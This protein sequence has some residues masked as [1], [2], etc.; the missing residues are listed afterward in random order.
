MEYLTDSNILTTKGRGRDMG[1]G[2]IGGNEVADHMKALDEVQHEAPDNCKMSVY[3]MVEAIKKALRL[4][5]SA[6]MVSKQNR[7]LLSI[8]LLLQVKADVWTIIQWAV[9]KV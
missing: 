9:G 1:N 3:R 8:L 2:N 6:C 4:G 5:E 7:I